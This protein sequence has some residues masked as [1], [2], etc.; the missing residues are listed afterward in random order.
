MLLMDIVRALLDDGEDVNIALRSC[1]R[2]CRRRRR[3]FGQPNSGVDKCIHLFPFLVEQKM[4]EWISH[5][6]RGSRF[7]APPRGPG[8]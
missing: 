4:L 2:R 5:F 1:R 8:V 3:L 6:R 7:W